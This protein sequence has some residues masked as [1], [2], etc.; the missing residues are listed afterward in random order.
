[1]LT[2]ASMLGIAL[3]YRFNDKIPWLYWLPVELR[4]GMDPE[5]MLPE[6]PEL[7]ANTLGAGIAYAFN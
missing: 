6:N 7:D 1:M 4:L 2:T 5:Y 3:E